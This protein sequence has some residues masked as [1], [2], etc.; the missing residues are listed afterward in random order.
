MACD[1][2]YLGLTG[3]WEWRPGES[4]VKERVE[5]GG[6]IWFRWC[7]IWRVGWTLHEMENYGCLQW[8]GPL[9]MSSRLPETRCGG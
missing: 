2:A 3:C 5:D 7:L 9:V 8:F 1:A 4:L 6:R